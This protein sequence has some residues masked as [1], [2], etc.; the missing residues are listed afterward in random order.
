MGRPDVIAPDC[1]N[2]PIRG[3]NIV[4][5]KSDIGTDSAS[6][7]FFIPLSEIGV[8][9]QQRAACSGLHPEERGEASAAG[10]N[11]GV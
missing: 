9:A 6:F 8:L 5:D 4:G 11:V 10:V 3:L 7:Y 1:C 2:L